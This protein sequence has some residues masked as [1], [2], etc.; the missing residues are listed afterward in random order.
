MRTSFQNASLVIELFKNLNFKE[1]E[2]IEILKYF[3]WIWRRQEYL[4]KINELDIYTDYAH[5]PTE[6]E[7]T[8]NSFKNQFKNTQIIWIF[9]VHQIFRF[10]SYKDDFLKSLKKFDKIFIYDI[11]SVR[12]EKILKKITWLDLPI[13]KQKQII[14]KWIAKSLNWKYIKNFNELKNMIETEK[15]IAV[16]MTAWDLDYKLRSLF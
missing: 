3:K 15:W 7:V 2:I 6:I 14:W 9:Q 4:W 11:Y 12:E 10:L 8:A 13:E 16:A 5:H 1:K